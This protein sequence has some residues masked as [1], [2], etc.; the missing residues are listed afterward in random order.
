[1]D[2]TITLVNPTSQIGIGLAGPGTV[3]LTALDASGMVIESSTFVFATNDY[4]YFTEG[5]SDIKS[6]Q[7]ESS[8]IAIDDLQ[9]YGGSATPEPSSIL[10]MVGGLGSLALARFRRS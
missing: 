2:T 10:M 6:L 7:I 9:F 5:S 1:M 8:F 3:T 4:W